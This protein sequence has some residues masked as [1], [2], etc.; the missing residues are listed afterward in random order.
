LFIFCCGIFYL[1]FY[2]MEKYQ[3]KA[4]A[5]FIHRRPD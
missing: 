4:Y 5:T 1:P 2:F 3:F